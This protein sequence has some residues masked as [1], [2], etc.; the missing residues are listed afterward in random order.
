MK[1]IKILLIF[2]YVLVMFG[3]K[4][5]PLDYRNKFLGDYTF[6][7]HYSW[8][9]YQQGSFDTTYSNEGKMEYGSDPH[10]VRAALSGGDSFEFTVY[11][12]GTIQGNQ[13]LGEFESVRKVKF[14]CYYGG[15]GGRTNYDVTGDKK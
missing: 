13:C 4:K 6:S 3:C 11:E 5:H 10:M 7:V 2:F 15:L 14:S 12:D 1:I 9:I 8:W